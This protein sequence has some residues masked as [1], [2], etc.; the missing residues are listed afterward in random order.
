MTDKASVSSS[1][2]SFRTPLDMRF[3]SFSIPTTRTSRQGRQTVQPPV[4]ERGK[5]P[6]SN[7]RKEYLLI[8]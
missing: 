5:N 4:I 6:T 7:Y 8:V 1:R 3:D 2:I